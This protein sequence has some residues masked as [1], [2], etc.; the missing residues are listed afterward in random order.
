MNEGKIK[1]EIRRNWTSGKHPISF[2]GPTNI[3]RYYPTVSKKVIE[4]AIS[5][6]DTYTLFREEKKPRYYNPIFVRKKR[7]IIQSDL[8]DLSSLSAE[9]DGVKYLLVVIDTFTRFAWIEPLKT[10]S[11]DDVLKGFQ[12]IER[13]M[14][15]GLGES[16]MTDQGKEYV[17]RQFQNYLK[18]LGVKV[19][20]PNNKCPHVERFNRTFQNLLYKYMEENQTH[21]YLDKLGGFVELYNNR[22]HRIIRT[23]PFLAEKPENYQS[24]LSAVE[25]YYTSAARAKKKKPSFKI[26]D[27]VRI[28]AHK[29]LFHKGYYQTFKPNV[30][31]VSEVLS[32][33]PE[34]MYKI[35][36]LE[37]GAVEAGSWYESELQ[38]V[39]QD[40]DNTV[41]KIEKVIKTRKKGEAKEALVKWKYWPESEN[42]WIPYSAIKDLR[43]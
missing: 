24:V 4:D 35:S 12:K 39:S 6:L 36:D 31:R 8:I 30:Y 42:S 3:Q 38:L 22:Y 32:H 10:K 29:N 25:R 20:V 34:T 18:R 37:S 43:K 16:L 7:E 40:Y 14:P 1:A 23:S 17:N 9:N 28:T 5:G 2:S 33:L 27:H 13:R 11:A 15:G 19:I 21:K 41:F 26:G